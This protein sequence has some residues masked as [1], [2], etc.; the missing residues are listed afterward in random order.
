M[1]LCTNLIVKLNLKF[2]SKQLTELLRKTDVTEAPL[3]CEPFKE[4]FNK[5][6]VACSTDTRPTSSTPTIVN[7][8][9]VEEEEEKR[10]EYIYEATSR[11]NKFAADTLKGMQRTVGNI[12]DNVMLISGF[13]ATIALTIKLLMDTPSTMKELDGGLSS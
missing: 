4:W 5:H 1:Q 12:F 9:S 6:I 11:H 7:A 3:Q 8:Q 2:Q 10:D 13:L